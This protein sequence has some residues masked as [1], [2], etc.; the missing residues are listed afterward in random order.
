M[1]H[2]REIVI[3]AV[4]MLLCHSFVYGANAAMSERDG[5]RV[6]AFVPAEG[7][8]TPPGGEGA[9]A[10]PV[11]LFK[12]WYIRLPVLGL[13]AYCAWVAVLLVAQNRMLFPITWIPAPE[14]EPD[15]KDGEVIRLPLKSG[16]E[17]EAWYFPVAGT[18]RRPLCVYFHGNGELID[19]NRHI[20]TGY[21]RLGIS[22]L[23][24]EYRGYGR[25]AGKP[26]QKSIVADGVRFRDLM[27]ER[28]KV[29]LERVIYHGRSLGGGVAAAV[30][31]ERA[32]AALVL[33]CT[34]LSVR[35][36]ASAYGAPGFLVR[37]PF[38]TDKALGV[39]NVPTIIFHGTQ[40]RIIPVKH[41]RGLAR[42]ARHAEFYEYPCGHNDFPGTEQYYDHW[43]KIERFLRAAE[44]LQ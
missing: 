21:H 31:V 5:N 19:D 18:G 23:M 26:S 7:S 10:S 34:F 20:V 17:V 39:L 28:P 8:D 25:C 41:G 30:A 27:A 1:K 43:R 44:I 37:N 33:D 35:S 6:A 2:T 9:T 13:L 15:V 3:A 38:R 12:R 22:V 4:I 29:D 24:P 40:D 42:I 11:P 32:P 16:G 14:A 36:M